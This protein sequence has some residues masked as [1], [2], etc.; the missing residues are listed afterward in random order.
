MKTSIQI[1]IVFLSV[2]VFLPAAHC[3]GTFQNLNFEMAPT[4]LG[5]SGEIEYY[6]IPNWNATMGPYLDGVT[7]NTY[8]LDATTVSLQTGTPIDGTASLFLTASSFGYPL[9]T[10][11]ISQTGLVPT[12]AKS[13]NFK[14]ANVMAFQVPSTLPGQFFVTM[15]GE[16]I[17]LLTVADFGSYIELAGDISNWDG[18][19]TTLSIGV[20]VPSSQGPENYYQGLIDD[21]SFSNFAVP[22][23]TTTS[24][25]F[26][27][28]VAFFLFRRFGL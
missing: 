14:V 23:P 22:E 8:V 28:G 21:I 10:A 27:A 15:N 17:A 13:L 18:D 12:T 11:S 16:N 24:I 9:S 6:Q 5:S 7:L 26:L 1:T 25:S 2:L 20:S 3:Q 4:D 19:T